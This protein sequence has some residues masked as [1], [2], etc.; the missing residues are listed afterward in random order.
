MALVHEGQRLLL[1]R[2][3]Q[4]GGVG[5]GLDDPVPARRSAGRGPTAAARG[6]GP[7]ISRRAAR[8]VGQ[9][10]LHLLGVAGVGHGPDEQVAGVEDLPLG[11][12]GPG[13]VVGLAPGVAQLEGV[14]APGEG[15]R[16]LV[17][18]VGLAELRGPGEPGEVDGELA[19]VDGRVPTDGAGV[20]G[21]VLGH[22]TVGVDHGTGPAPPG[23]LGLE[24]G[25]AED[26]VDVV[27]GVHGGGQGV[28]GPPLPH[29]AVH[30][31]P[32]EGAAGVEH[33]QAVP[34]VD[35][36]D[37]GDA[38]QVEHAVGDLLAVDLA[39]VAGE[40]GHRVVGVDQVAPTLPVL[41]GQL[42]DGRHGRTLVPSTGRGQG[43][44]G[45]GAGSVVTSVTTARS[46]SW[47]SM[48]V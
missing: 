23:R 38:L 36:V 32:V 48:I 14:V 45:Q 40:A 44:R 20:A 17:G 35:G 11:D 37:R 34:G 18:D 10:A 31:L 46:P 4:L 21:E 41:L 29:L 47:S 1:D 28:G 26:V 30:D 19:A 9:V 27:V 42:T 15:E 39:V 25:G 13:G 8:P 33:D 22:V 24:Q 16:P 6:R 5:Q 3:Q 7:A 12:P 43:E 2:L